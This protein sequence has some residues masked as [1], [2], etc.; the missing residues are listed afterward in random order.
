MSYLAA[1]LLLYF[2]D[3]FECFLAFASLLN[4]HFFFDCYQLKQ[5]KIDVHLRVFQYFFK[6]KLPVLYDLFLSHGIDPNSYYLEWSLTL[7]VKFLPFNICARIWDSYFLVGE[8]FFL[9]SSLG[10]INFASLFLFLL[11]FFI[12]CRHTSNAR[13]C[14]QPH[15]DGWNYA[16]SS[17]FATS[18]P[19]FIFLLYTQK[20]RFKFT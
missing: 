4:M 6:S 9:R 15:G 7:F 10:S 3:S 8:S 14:S 20:A 16:F 5:D 2:D 11:T 18:A 19:E 17:T 12:I 1:E 13:C